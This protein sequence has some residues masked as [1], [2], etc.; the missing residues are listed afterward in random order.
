MEHISHDELVTLKQWLG[1]GSINIFG[2]PFSGKD[3][4]GH[5]LAQLFDASILGGGDIFRN[6]VIPDAARRIMDAGGLV[7]TEDFVRIVTPY[8]SHEQFTGKPLILSIIGRS[9][10]EE[11]GVMEATAAANHPTKAV[12]Y[13]V[14]SESTARERH[15]AS[16]EDAVRGIRADDA[17]HVLET[18]FAEFRNKTMPVIEFYREKGLLIEIDGN[19]PKDEVHTAILR[20]LLEFA[21]RASA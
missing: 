5:M 10:G 13:L 18:R 20:G 8:L 14:T 9:H 6:S 1:S 4:H 3:T 11:Q 21:N 15:T 2:L 17:E 19:P 12:I 7:P 16:R